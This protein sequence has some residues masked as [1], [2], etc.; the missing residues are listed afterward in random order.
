[1]TMRFG[2]PPTTSTALHVSLRL[3]LPSDGEGGSASECDGWEWD[4]VCGNSGCLITEASTNYNYDTMS[5]RICEVTSFDGMCMAAPSSMMLHVWGEVK[6]AHEIM[7]RTL[8]AARRLLAEPW[9]W[10]LSAFVIPLF[11]PWALHLLKRDAEAV[12]LMRKAKCDWDNVEDTVAAFT[13]HLDLL[14]P[15][16]SVSPRSS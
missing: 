16:T 12:E 7:D 13:E 5:K 15:T 2:V 1:M 9:P 4:D 3:L 8:C 11:L 14:G 6:T 10:S